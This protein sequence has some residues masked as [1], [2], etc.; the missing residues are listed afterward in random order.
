M[1]EGT[2]LV[3]GHRPWQ[4]PP[5]LEYTAT[6]TSAGCSSTSDELGAYMTRHS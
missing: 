2:Q 1:N 4:P 3:D 5:R 6:C